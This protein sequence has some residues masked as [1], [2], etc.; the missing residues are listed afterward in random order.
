MGGSH[1]E[2]RKDD[3]LLGQISA[4]IKTVKGDVKGIK[5]K[6]DKHGEDL[7]ALK[8]KASLWGFASGAISTI[9]LWAK[10]SFSK[11]GQG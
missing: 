9:A 7:A 10:I 5:I 1:Q 8:V 4:D 6:V 2:R 3:F 11:G